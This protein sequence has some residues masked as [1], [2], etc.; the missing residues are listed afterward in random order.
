MKHLFGLIVILGLFVLPASA[1]VWEWDCSTDPTALDLNGDSI[2]DWVVRGGGP[3]NAD[4][5]SGGYWLGGQT[6]DTRP[7]NYFDYDTFVDLNWKATKVGDWNATFWI[8]MGGP[9]TLALAPVYAQLSNDGVSQTLTVYNVWKSWEAQVLVTV[10]ELP[11][12]FVNTQL[13]FDAD[14]AMLNVVIDGVD[15]G[16]YEY[17]L[18]GPPNADRFATILGGGM[19]LD[20]IRIETVP[21]PATML[22]LGAGLAGL[23][24]RKRRS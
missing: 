20:S 24:I 2:N 11:N 19:E 12:D 8:N 16:T 5:L 4:Q 6:V 18:W 3:F 9:G 23:L 22:L 1:I 7:M 13:N 15:Y 14:N 21:E 17:T 10:T